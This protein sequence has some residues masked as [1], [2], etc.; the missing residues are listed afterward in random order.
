MSELEPI[1]KESAH[2]LSWCRKAHLASFHGTEI[3]FTCI[4]RGDAQNTG[5]SRPASHIRSCMDTHTHIDIML[6][7]NKIVLSHCMHSQTLQHFAG[8]L[9]GVENH[10]YERTYRSPLFSCMCVL[11]RVCSCLRGNT[12]AHLSVC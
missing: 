8:I 5:L 4:P 9:D 2:Q 7:Y 11:A 1:K 3:A 6:D 12:H 10:N